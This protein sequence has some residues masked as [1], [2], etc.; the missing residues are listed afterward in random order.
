MFEVIN[1]LYFL[2]D[3][4]EQLEDRVSESTKENQALKQQI[5]RLSSENQSV[6]SQLKKLQAQ[7]GQN[8]KRTTQAGRCL[9]VFMLSACLL[10]SPQ[11]SPLVSWKFQG[12]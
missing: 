3:Y 4:I 8:A 1:K 2:Q 7:L 5:E 10:V 11:L 12:I 9:A 6:I